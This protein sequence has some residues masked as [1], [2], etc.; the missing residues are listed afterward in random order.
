MCVGTR[1]DVWGTSM[2]PACTHR[3]T[4]VVGL[5]KGVLHDLRLAQMQRT[6]LI[7]VRGCVEGKFGHPTHYAIHV[8]RRLQWRQGKKC[9]VWIIWIRGHHSYQLTEPLKMVLTFCGL[10]PK[11]LLLNVIAYCFY[12]FRSCL[13]RAPY[14]LQQQ[15]HPLFLK[16]QILTHLCVT[17]IR[18]AQ[19]EN[20]YTWSL[21]RKNFRW[22]QSYPM[23]ILLLAIF[24]I[25]RM[26]TTFLCS[27]KELHE[28]ESCNASSVASMW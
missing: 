10:E 28:W 13:L 2:S 12:C 19:H 14:H 18:I 7:M 22:T 24:D 15:I 23:L 9:E 1:C 11:Q 8:T 4:N 21:R 17:G 25:Y 20:W 5:E 16:S 27:S 3:L 26:Q 6:S